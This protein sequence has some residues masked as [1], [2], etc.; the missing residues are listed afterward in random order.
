ML[1]VSGQHHQEVYF[2]LSLSPSVR[3][4]RRQIHFKTVIWAELDVSS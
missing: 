4:S 1:E 3:G 2:A